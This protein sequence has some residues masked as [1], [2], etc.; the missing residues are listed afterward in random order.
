MK[1]KLIILGLLPAVCALLTCALPVEGFLDDRGDE[2]RLTDNA[3]VEYDPVFYETLS[4]IGDI[5]NAMIAYHDGESVHLYDYPSDTDEVIYTAPEGY[6]I[7]AMNSITEGWARHGL[8]LA[9]EGN[10][11]A[12]IVQEDGSGFIEI[13]RDSGGRID[14]ISCFSDTKDNYYFSFERNGGIYYGDTPR[15]NPFAISDEGSFAHLT[16]GSCPV[17]GSHWK[18]IIY[19][20]DV[21]GVDCIYLYDFVLGEPR[22]ELIYSDGSNFDDLSSTVSFSNDYDVLIYATSDREG[23]F[24][25]WRCF[26]HS[27]LSRITD[28]SGIE[29][30]ICA[31]NDYVVFSRTVDGQSDLYIVRGFS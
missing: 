17:F 6:T 15:E 19:I 30:D 7:T 25:I 10:G 22:E 1:R 12:V 14:N 18:Y 16:D 24:G 31:W 5:E 9:L 27:D 23:E 4:Y 21:A 26:T 11:E 28:K 3:L 20:K 8:V 2:V 29:R 13:Y